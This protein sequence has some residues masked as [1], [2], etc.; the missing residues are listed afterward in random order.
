MLKNIQKWLANPKR[1]YAEGLGYFNRFASKKQKD[2]FGSF[3]NDVKEDE[4][5]PQFDAA[6]R[7]PILVNQVIFIQK[8][9]TTN[10]E[11]FK[12]VLLDEVPEKTPVKSSDPNTAKKVKAAEKLSQDLAAEQARLK[13][14][15][16]VM[17]KLHADM[18]DE[19]IADDKRA[20]IRAELVQLDD[21]RRAIWAKID[22]AGV[23][24]ER[25]EEETEVEKNMMALG[26][27][28]ALRI[29]Q[30]KSYITR[31]EDALKKHTDA[32]NQKKAD[33]AKEKIEL[34]KAELAE[35]EKLI[36]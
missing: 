9:I 28:T 32:K 19:K 2:T 25:S 21:E 27:K 7:F 11:A 33:N 12:K 15:V 13:E 14:L 35:L 8:G 23:E 16:P 18:S 34:Y 5:V 10:A 31:N 36:K 20:A 3:L 6:G 29:G 22:S 17:A 30:L 26:A 1:K 24:I 4:N